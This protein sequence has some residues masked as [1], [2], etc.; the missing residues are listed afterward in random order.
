MALLLAVKMLQ[1]ILIWPVIE[2]I[3][4]PDSVGFLERPLFGQNEILI[5][6]LVNSDLHGYRHFQIV[7][8]PLQK[9]VKKSGLSDSEG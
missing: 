6:Q 7:S 9:A 5:D 8:R 4:I 2:D 1:F 3:G